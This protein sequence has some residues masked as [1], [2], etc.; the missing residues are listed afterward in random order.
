MSGS[1][2]LNKE[3]VDFLIFDCK[4]EKSKEGGEVNDVDEVGTDF[5]S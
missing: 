4:L 2:G 5:M 3:S 1:I